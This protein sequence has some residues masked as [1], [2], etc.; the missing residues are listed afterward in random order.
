MLFLLLDVGGHLA[1]CLFHHHVDDHL[2]R[3]GVI[4]VPL[5]MF[6]GV[7]LVLGEQV[8][9]AFRTVSVD[10]VRNFFGDLTLVDVVGSSHPSTSTHVWVSILDALD[11][12]VSQGHRKVFSSVVAPDLGQCS[13]LASHHVCSVGDHRNLF[14]IQ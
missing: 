11:V 10:C 4:V 13:R 9:H 8:V 2:D 3:V 1:S 5:G 12:L 6:A 7:V 14:V